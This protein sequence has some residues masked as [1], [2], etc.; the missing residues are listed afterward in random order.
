M[1][2]KRRVA[3][4]L[5]AFALAAGLTAIPALATEE[6]PPSAYTEM[7]T[8]NTEGETVL[9]EEPVEEPSTAPVP[10]PVTPEPPVSSNSSSSSE[11]SSESSSSENSNNSS[12]TPQGGITSEQP[13]DTSSEAP[14]DEPGET[15]EEPWQEPTEEPWQPSETESQAPVGGGITNDV[16]T[17]SAP[18]TIATPRPSLER[19]QVS[20]N[21]GSGSSSESEEESGPNYVTFAQLNVRGN[22]LAVTLFYSGVGCIAAGV[23]GLVAILVFYIRGR[24]RHANAEGILEEIHEAETRQNPGQRHGAPPVREPSEVQA[25]PPQRPARSVPPGAVMPEEVSLYTEE[26]SMPPAGQQVQGEVPGGYEE[27]GYGENYQEYRED[28]PQDEYY[29]DEYYDDGY[30]EEEPLPPAENPAP[31]PKAPVQPQAPAPAQDQE[32][33]RQFDT[34]EILREALRYYDDK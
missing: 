2:H 26:F 17:V 14:W 10:D 23:L 7:P 5:A 34:E 6:N 11:T 19:P 4:L 15:S 30:Y 32:A 21:A 29:E 20:L 8:E 1:K 12:S 3:A 28:Y 33:T 27:E 22:S 16:P 25:P 18:E 13:S 9:P 31:Q 24:R